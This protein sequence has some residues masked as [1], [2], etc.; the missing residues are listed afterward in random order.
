MIR[1][2]S[3]SEDTYDWS[4]S[5]RFALRSKTLELLPVCLDP[6]RRLELSRQVEA[7]FIAR[8]GYADTYPSEHLRTVVVDSFPSLGKL[9]ALRCAR[10]GFS[11]SFESSQAQQSPSSRGYFR[12]VCSLF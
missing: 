7:A 9:A 11:R 6:G 8:S 12:A 10:G 3:L 1:A 5:R 2:K 4:Y